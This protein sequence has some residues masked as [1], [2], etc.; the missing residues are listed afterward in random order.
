[1]NHKHVMFAILLALASAT[2]FALAA[3]PTPAPQAAAA[4]QPA[5]KPAGPEFFVFDNGVGRG[6][7]TPEQQA[8]TLQELGYDGIS[9]NYTKPADLEAWQK[10]CKA[11]GLKIYGLYVYTYIDKPEHYDPKFKEAIKLLKGTDTIIWMTVLTKAKGDQDAEAVKIIQDIAD[12]AAANGVRVSLYGHAGMY[13]ASAS[14][15]ARL[16]KLANRPNVGASINLCHEF[17]TK[18][19]DKLDET[20]KSAAAIS[21]LASINGVDEK[22]KKYILRL[23]QGDFD[24]VGYLKKLYAAGYKGPVGL[25]CYSVTG[26]IKENLKADIDAWRKIKAQLAQP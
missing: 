15:S 9:Y 2:M 16:A 7:W 1:M 5:S 23:D 6:K 24:V 25:Q 21:T 26:D 22:S 11:H 14:D 13:T 18:N 20:I 19:G 17:L 12:Q 3:E 4:S 8:A 10:A